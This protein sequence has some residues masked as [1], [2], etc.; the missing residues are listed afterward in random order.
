MRD[1]NCLLLFLIVF[2]LYIYIIVIAI[3]T[4]PNLTQPKD[5]LA[6]KPIHNLRKFI[7]RGLIDESMPTG[8]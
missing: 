2:L 7:Y 4:S 8:N 3:C 1:T 6:F 5:E